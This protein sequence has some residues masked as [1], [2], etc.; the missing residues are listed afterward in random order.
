M[1][2]FTLRP[3]K[4]PN[5]LVAPI[6][7]DQRYIDQLTNA[8]R[9]YFNQVDNVT[10]T[11]LGPDGGKYIQN[12]HIAASDTTDQYA[13]GDN[14][15]TIVKWNTLDSGTGFTLN[16]SYTATCLESGVFKIDYSLQYANT[17]NAPHD[18]IVWLK[19]NGA[20]VARS[21]SKITITSRKS[22]GVPSYVLMYSTVTF[23]VETGDEIGLW[24]ATDKA[25]NTTGPVDGVYMEYIPAQTSPYPHPSAPSA[26]GAITFVSRLPT[27]L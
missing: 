27:T 9:L 26:I 14:D 19:V 15:P 7:Y 1:A 3:S 12:P 4:A 20:D 13:D 17:A 21:A 5:L 16:P 2:D 8:L 11:V 18:V 6:V 25:Y 22:A 23:E 24:W 10:G